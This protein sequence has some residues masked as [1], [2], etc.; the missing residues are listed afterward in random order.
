MSKNTPQPFEELRPADD[1]VASRTATTLSG[2]TSYAE[3]EKLARLNDPAT[4]EMEIPMLD[5]EL[6][7]L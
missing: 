5:V 7:A 1:G 4:R 6:E 2:P 3:L